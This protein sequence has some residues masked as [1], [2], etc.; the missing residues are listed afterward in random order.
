M[1]LMFHCKQIKKSTKI[2]N[3]TTIV[4]FRSE[5]FFL[6]NDLSVAF[7]H[8]TIILHSPINLGDRFRFFHLIWFQMEKK[9]VSSYRDFAFCDL[10][11]LTPSQFFPLPF[12]VGGEKTPSCF[13]RRFLV[14]FSVGFRFSPFERL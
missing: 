10:E 4:E 2:I 5:Q 1:R 12:A 8:R 11:F 9:I 7:R 3:Y 14:K 6:C 13:A